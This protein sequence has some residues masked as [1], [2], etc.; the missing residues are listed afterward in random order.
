MGRLST[1]YLL[2]LTS[3]DQLLFLIKILFAYVTK[4]AALMRRSTVLSLS[5]SVSVPWNGLRRVRVCAW[6]KE[7]MQ[8]EWSIL[9]M[10]NRPND[11]TNTKEL[12]GINK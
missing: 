11:I 5:P 6:H 12:H 8:H 9:N 4:Q 7:L 10:S 2:V 3:L 1:V